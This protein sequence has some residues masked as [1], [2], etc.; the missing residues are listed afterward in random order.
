[1]TVRLGFAVAAHLEPEILVVDEVLA[2]G[3]AE[4]QK[5]AIGKMQDLST[6]EGRTV[7]F[8]SHNMGSVRK[9]CN[10]AMVL[11]NGATGLTGDVAD[12][13]D[14]YLNQ[15]EN[16]SSHGKKEFNFKYFG[17]ESLQL[18]EVLIKDKKGRIRTTFAQ[19][20]EIYIDVKF[21][22]FAKLKGARFNLLLRTA[23]GEDV[24]T[25]SSHF[26]TKGGIEVGK[27]TLSLT[28]PS[29]LLNQKKYIFVIN[30]GIP[31]R[32]VIIEPTDVSMVDILNENSGGSDF[33]EKS[34]GVV[35]PK[36]HWKILKE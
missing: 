36:I 2:V 23:A 16:T 4:F 24:F 19:S 25:T 22:T 11:E 12:C 33:V 10:R 14:Y 8:V 15:N 31:G 18:L 35:A 20:E 5:K 28:I 29:Y 1:M 32:K 26:L 17:D 3:D 7:L 34:L 21:Q 27:N 30:A 9:L 13:I 6:G